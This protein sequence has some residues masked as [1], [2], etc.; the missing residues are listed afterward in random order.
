MH[1]PCI[2][3]DFSIIYRKTYNL[4]VRL[5]ARGLVT[6]P[7]STSQKFL[8]LGMVSKRDQKPDVGAVVV[9]YLDFSKTRGKKCTD[10]DYEKWYARPHNSECLIGH[11]VCHSAKFLLVRTN[12][13]PSNG[14]NAENQRQ[15]VSWVTSSKILLDMKRT[16]LARTKIMSG[17]FPSTIRTSRLADEIFK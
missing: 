12:L 5:A 8:L 13:L 17:V 1:L 16:V 15:T 10:G 6:L 3:T 9:V 2:P 14:T 11:K 7:D 4:G